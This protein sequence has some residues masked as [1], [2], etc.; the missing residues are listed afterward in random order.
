MDVR[1]AHPD[2]PVMSL[3]LPAI[4]PTVTKAARHTTHLQMTFR[5]AE[6]HSYGDSRVQYPRYSKEPCFATKGQD[7][8][9]LHFRCW[10]SSVFDPQAHP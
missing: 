9:G 8:A 7:A 2:D 5:A 1:N 10:Q 3:F 4:C 6:P